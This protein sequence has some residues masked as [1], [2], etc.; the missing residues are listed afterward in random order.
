MN[1]K[2]ELIISL[3]VFPYCGHWLLGYC[4]GLCLETTLTPFSN[5]PFYPGVIWGQRT[6]L[7]GWHQFDVVVEYWLSTVM[8]SLKWA[9]GRE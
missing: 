2:A 5:L 1:T 3:I 9:W 7:G 6:A 8:G 4:S